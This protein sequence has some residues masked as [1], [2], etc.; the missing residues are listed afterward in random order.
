MIL[1]YSLNP[2]YAWSA[3]E[4]EGEGAGTA[5]LRNVVISIALDPSSEAKAQH[6]A[7]QHASFRR[8]TA[9]VMWKVPELVVKQEQERMLARL[10]TQ[11]GS[12]KRGG[13]EVKFEMPDRGVGLGLR[14]WVVGEGQGEGSV[15]G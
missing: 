5:T 3:S 1:L 9:S 12:A 4:G 6:R 15:C 13:V 7:T 14:R 10:L 11:G 2:T 8:K